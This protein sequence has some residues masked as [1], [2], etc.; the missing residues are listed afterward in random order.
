[1][2]QNQGYTTFK[3]TGIKIKYTHVDLGKNQVTAT[4]SLNGEAQMTVVTD[5][6]IHQVNKEGSLRKVLDVLPDVD[7]ESYIEQISAWSKIF[8]EK[9]ITDPE[10]YFE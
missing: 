1:M 10:Q 6:A 8:I 9:K 2:D 3:P 7:E 4:I 5:L